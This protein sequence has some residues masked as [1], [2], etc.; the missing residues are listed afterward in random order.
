MRLML[1]VLTWLAII[2]A[3]SIACGWA[4]ILLLRRGLSDDR[5]DW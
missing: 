3:I 1:D 4:L 5:E 2:L